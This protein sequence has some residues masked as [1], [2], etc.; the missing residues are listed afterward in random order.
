MLKIYAVLGSKVSVYTVSLS[1][2]TSLNEYRC[3]TANIFITR[4]DTRAEID[5][6][7]ELARRAGAF[8]AVPCYHWSVGG[9]GSVELARA[10]RDAASKGSRFRFLYDV[11]VSSEAVRAAL[12]VRGASAENL[13]AFILFIGHSHPPDMEAAGEGG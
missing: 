10:V 8:D 5:L 3:E 12:P 6:V 7:C 4:T 11:Q 13:V 1:L 2:K 9:K